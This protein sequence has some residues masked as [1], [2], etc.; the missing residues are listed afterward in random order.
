MQAL[1]EVLR[2]FDGRSL[3]HIVACNGRRLRR[4]L[5]EF[6]NRKTAHARTN[7]FAPMTLASETRSRSAQRSSSW[8]LAH[9]LSARTASRLL[10]SAW[11]TS[12]RRCWGRCCRVRRA[13][14]K[15]DLHTR[16]T[17]LRLVQHVE[18]K[19]H[20]CVSW[21]HR[22]V[23]FFSWRGNRQ[24]RESESEERLCIGRGVRES[25]S[26]VVN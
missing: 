21:L 16:T 23:R 4:G 17:T 3:R 26:S 8:R 13:E 1:G 14:W 12:E 20:S 11:P 19:D 15:I 5:R 22:D 18:G 9:A 6:A 24:A 7:V 25:R 10:L 2:S